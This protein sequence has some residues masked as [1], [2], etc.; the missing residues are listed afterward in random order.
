M[1][2]PIRASRNRA[3]DPPICE[4]PF[5]QCYLV[6]V[7]NSLD[8]TAANAATE[9]AAKYL[10]SDATTPACAFLEQYRQMRRKHSG[11]PGRC[12]LAVR[13]LSHQL[14]SRAT[15]PLRRRSLLSAAG[16]T[17]RGQL[18]ASEEAALP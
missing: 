16:G 11:S 13:A 17:L 6:H 10:E 7:G 9:M 1:T 2:H 12:R 4:I 8:E 18:T 3:C 14:S 5:Q 15:H